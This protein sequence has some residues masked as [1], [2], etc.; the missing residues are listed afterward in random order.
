[1]ATSKTTAENKTEAQEERTLAGFFFSFPLTE[2]LNYGNAQAFI[3]KVKAHNLNHLQ[4]LPGVSV[5]DY[6]RIYQ[7]EKNNGHLVPDPSGTVIQGLI[8]YH[9][10]VPSSTLPFLSDNIFGLGLEVLWSKRDL[11]SEYEKMDIDNLY[12]KIEQLDEVYFE[13]FYLT[14]PKKEQRGLVYN[15]NRR[16]NIGYYYTP[17]YFRTSPESFIDITFK[18]IHRFDA[19]KFFTKA[20]NMNNVLDQGFFFN[21]D[22]EKEVCFNLHQVFE[23]LRHLFARDEIYAIEKALQTVT[24]LEQLRNVEQGLKDSLAPQIDALAGSIP[25][26]V[27]G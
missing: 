19:L 23:K 17:W 20:L 22:T 15:V 10:S 24:L 11:D 12:P 4:L 1:M 6:V 16:P 7:Y 2:I 5:D 13:S 27:I 25:L 21:R 9:E 14:T 26:T 18:S 3:D 8:A